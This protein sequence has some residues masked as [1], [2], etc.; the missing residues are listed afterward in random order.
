VIAV[1]DLRTLGKMNGLDIVSAAWINIHI[2]T[3]SMGQ[4]SGEKIVAR[5]ASTIPL[6]ASEK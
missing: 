3:V 6:S 1:M 5:W 2:G 4:D